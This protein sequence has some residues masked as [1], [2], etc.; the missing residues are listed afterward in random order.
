MVS[1]N[2]RLHFPIPTFDTIG[3]RQ[4]I[5]KAIVNTPNFEREEILGH[6]SFSSRV[7]FLKEA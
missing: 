3:T 1:S 6:T 2:C 4:I 7:I 5:F